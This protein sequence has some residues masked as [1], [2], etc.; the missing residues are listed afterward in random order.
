MPGRFPTIRGAGRRRSS[1]LALRLEP[2]FLDEALM[3]LD[4]EL[5]DDVDEKVQQAL[6]V[7]ARQFAAARILLD[8]QHELLE[9]Q[10]GARCM[11]A[12]DGAGVARIDVAQVIE[13][14]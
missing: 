1:A 10:F 5:D 8:Q 7:A 6:D 4:A 13:G 12:G 3:P 11:D 9:G 2:D 14:L